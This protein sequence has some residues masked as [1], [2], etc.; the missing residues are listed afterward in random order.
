MTDITL[1]A[2]NTLSWLFT[3]GPGPGLDDLGQLTPRCILRGPSGSVTITAVVFSALDRTIAVS[4]SA[5]RTA[6]L[7]PGLYQVDL[8]L[9]SPGWIVQSSIS[10][11]CLIEEA[12]TDG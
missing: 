11:T 8:Q 6:A 5:E 4:A 10:R 2:G 9:T 3:V 1:R 12:L 7:L